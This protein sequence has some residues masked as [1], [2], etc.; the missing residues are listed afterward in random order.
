MIQVHY[1]YCAHYFYYYFISS[2]SDHQALDPWSKGRHCNVG[3]YSILSQPSVNSEF[4]ILHPPINQ[5][6]LNQSTDTLFCT[7]PGMTLNLFSLCPSES[8]VK[9]QKNRWDPQKSWSSPRDYQKTQYWKWYCQR[10]HKWRI[11]IPATDLLRATH[12][13]CNLFKQNQVTLETLIH[14]SEIQC[15]YLLFLSPELWQ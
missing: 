13:F 6:S 12:Y 1:I 4:L 11:T 3:P 5:S 10:C 14:I 9:W 8:E 15:C 2:S 7:P